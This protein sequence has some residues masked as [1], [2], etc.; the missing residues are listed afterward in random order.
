MRNHMLIKLATGISAMAVCASITC[1]AVTITH[2]QDLALQ[3]LA[4]SNAVSIPKFNPL[5]GTL[6]KITYTL[7]GHI[8]GDARG[9][10]LDASPA[11]VN[12][13]LAASLTL[14]RPDQS[15][16]LTDL[17]SI[18]RSFNASAFD[19]TIDFGG[20]SGQTFSGLISD[21]TETAS[22][23][24]LLL[25]DLALFTGTG[26]ILLP[27]VAAGT[28]SGT[29]AGNLITQFSTRASARVT[30][31]YEYTPSTVPEGGM[32]LVTLAVGLLSLG[33]LR[34]YWR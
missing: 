3:T 13:N 15:I 21:V 8:E 32:T 23:P 5:L 26:D 19:G 22:S 28:S 11:T 4:W 20:T 33:G 18:S 34:R 27:V 10:S 16:I 1:S 30:V 6:T 14:R 9:E 25:S 31:E 2:S 29:G 7:A 17:P 24:P 12:L